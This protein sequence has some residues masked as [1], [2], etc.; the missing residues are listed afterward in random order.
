MM[1]SLRTAV[2]GAG[3]FA[4]ENHIPALLERPEVVLD[5]VCRLGAAELGRVRAHFGFAFASEDYR[6]VLQRRPDLVIVASPH[7][8]H[9]EH[10]RAALE[11]GAH[12]LCEKPMTLDPREAWDL[13][14]IARAQGRALVIANSYNYLPHLDGLRQRI[15]EGL[16]GEIE[17]VSC[18]FVSATREVFVGTRGLDRWA[19]SF[20]RPDPSTWQ[21]PA[22]GG[23]FAFGQLSHALALMYFMIGL[24]PRR[25]SGLV[26]GSGGVDLANAAVIS[27]SNGAVASV[28]G[29]A[30]LPQGRRA[31]MRLT[32]SGSAGVADIDIDGTRC[33]IFVNGQCETLPLAEGAWTL[34]SKA[35]VHAAVDLALGRGRNLSPGEIGAMTTATIRALLESAAQGGAPQEALAAKE[36][37]PP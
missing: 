30:T 5:G 3:W 13:V 8:M 28:S 34:D 4:C 37:T 7:A 29:S 19:T 22:A 33:E 20:A 10:A 32:V 1:K 17:H 36:I 11:A 24:T 12:V 15:A 27:L 25:V 14:A 18:T 26:G 35:P 16:I 31:L 6:A 2:I 9:F 23:G 21:D